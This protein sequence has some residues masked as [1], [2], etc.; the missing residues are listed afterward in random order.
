M[1]ETD[2]NRNTVQAD[3]IAAEG[4]YTNM[5][6]LPVPE[7][8]DDGTVQMP[9]IKAEDIFD[10][11]ITPD[12][13][14]YAASA[15]IC[16]IEKLHTDIQPTD[17]DP[18]ANREIVQTINLEY[19]TVDVYAMNDNIWIVELTFDS[20][21]DAYLTDLRDHMN[22]YKTM[23]ME[24]R[25]RA[26]GDPDFRTNVIP[27]YTITFVPYKYSG[28]GVAS[29]GDPIDFYEVEKSGG[30]RGFHIMFSPDSMNFEQIEMTK[31]QLADT[32][33]EVQREEEAKQNTV[34]RSSF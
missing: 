6:V 17:E 31:D 12:E 15:I 21:N 27:M 5:D 25:Q 34:Y 4:S 2:D 18:Q 26:M 33:A 24:L 28:F 29:F 23:M 8:K 10:A 1:N 30:K 16:A 9:E 3:G 32:Q 7:E 22:R 11:I 19:C 20:E 14:G 13:N